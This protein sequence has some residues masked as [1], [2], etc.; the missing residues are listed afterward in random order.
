MALVFQY[1]SNTSAARLNGHDRLN[2][3]ASVFGLAR[4]AANYELRFEV[5][6]VT[7]NCAAANIRPGGQRPVWGVLYDVPDHLI[8]RNTAGSARSLDAIEGECQN[9][10]R[11]EIDVIGPGCDRAVRALTYVAKNPKDGI[12]TSF[13][14]AACIIKGLREHDA[15]A[16]YIQHVKSVVAVNNPV[17]A[18]DVGCL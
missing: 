6:S 2:G 8:R 14:Y 10:R 5:W 7:N 16:E 9:Y 12:R 15:P 1:G 4:T 17:I 18:G 3:M 13:D 11:E